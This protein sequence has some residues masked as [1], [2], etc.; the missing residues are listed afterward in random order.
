MHVCEDH[1]L[2]VGETAVFLSQPSHLGLVMIVDETKSTAASRTYRYN[3]KLQSL[4][5]SRCLD[6]ISQERRFKSD[7]P[8]RGRMTRR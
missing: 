8:D 4:T 6:G 2:T 3:I 7:F 1:H 5:M